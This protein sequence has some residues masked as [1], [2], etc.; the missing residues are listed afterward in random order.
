MTGTGGAWTALEA[1][2]A[3]LSAPEDARDRRALALLAS[4]SQAELRPLLQ[5]PWPG[6]APH[7]PEHANLFT[8]RD[9]EL[10]TLADALEKLRADH[11]PRLL[12]LAGG[13]GTGKTSLV[14]AGLI[15]RLH[16]SG[17][18]QVRGLRP[19]GD[20][21]SRIGTAIGHPPQTGTEQLVVV[22]PFEAVFDLPSSERQRVIRSLWRKASEP[23]GPVSVLLCLR[24]EYLGRCGELIVDETGTR[25]DAVAFSEAHQVLLRDPG[26]RAL[27]AMLSRP[28]E[29]A[30]LELDPELAHRIAGTVAGLSPPLPHLAAAAGR[31]WAARSGRRLT[32]ASWRAIG[33]PAEAIAHFADHVLEGLPPE[34]RPEALRVLRALTLPGGRDGPARG[35]WHTRAHLR[36]HADNEEERHHDAIV[37][38]LI[39]GGLLQDERGPEGDGLTLSHDQLAEAWPRLHARV[40]TAAGEVTDPKV[41]IEPAPP[42]LRRPPPQSMPAWPFVLV[43]VLALLVTASVLAW[44]S[45]ARQARRDAD[46]AL[47]AA[48]DVRDDPTEAALQLRLSAG[49]RDRLLWTQLAN[50]TLHETLSQGVLRGLDG[51]VEALQFS[52][53]GDRILTLSGGVPALWSVAR[54]AA[55][56]AR[57]GSITGSGVVTAAF[58]PDGRAVLLVTR[59]GAIFQ[60]DPAD[61]EPRRIWTPD[62]S[63]NTAAAVAI[64]GTGSHVLVATEGGWSIIDHTGASVASGTVPTED[65]MAAG[66]PT[67]A[68]LDQD[69]TRWAIASRDG[70]VHLWNSELPDPA[71]IRHPGVSHIEINAEGSHLLSLG[72]GRLRLTDLTHMRGVTRTPTPVQVHTATFS[73]IGRHILVDYT[74]RDSGEHHARTLSVD[75]RTEQFETEPLRVP[76]TA[77][78]I[79]ETRDRLL[80]GRED[81]RVEELDRRDGRVLRVLRGHRGRVTALRMSPDGRWLASASADQSVRIWSNRDPEPARFLP[82]PPGLGTADQVGLTADGERYLAHLESSGWVSQ[83]LDPAD[84][85][86]EEA[87]PP[88]ADTAEVAVRGTREGSIEAPDGERIRAFEV[89]TTATCTTPDGRYVGAIS[90]AGDIARWDRKTGSLIHLGAADPAPR[91]CRISED[92]TT[93]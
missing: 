48:K 10:D 88:D 66:A 72:D 67:T 91:T 64:S 41:E 5:R 54:D 49:A 29:R 26:P 36:P 16:E 17:P 52:P 35:T 8:G 45:G 89:A 22:D 65:G 30:G 69:G 33:E 18:W 14:Q 38:H 83:S 74:H 57:A 27:R 92:G 62:T 86:T 63:S 21:E 75:L 24:I 73:P 79:D 82:L 84:L 31:M 32:D 37:A 59:T 6:L 25:L 3:T 60:W 46:A 4:D 55:P 50:S 85:A 61:G 9:D 51:P 81:G 87:A 71:R 13:S 34:R 19:T 42:R 7:G 90:Q 58:R 12:L 77:L 11:A 68:A 23:G 1:A 2:R 76:A 39:Q 15:P 43:S 93:L 56:I 20:I 78:L 28:A 80:R 53:E 44:G 40:P 70:S 47:L